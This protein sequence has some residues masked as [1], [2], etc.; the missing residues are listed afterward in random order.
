MA[1]GRA[2]PNRINKRERQER[3]SCTHSIT[4]GHFYR[5]AGGA[6]VLPVGS[7]LCP[8]FS[9]A[10]GGL[11]PVPPRTRRQAPCRPCS[12]PHLPPPLTPE[13]AALTLTKGKELKGCLNRCPFL[14]SLSYVPRPPLLPQACSSCACVCVPKFHPVRR[15][16]IKGC[17]TPT[18]KHLLVE[19][20]YAFGVILQQLSREV[21][22]AASVFWGG[23]GDDSDMFTL[24]TADG[25]GREEPSSQ[26]I[27]YPL[28]RTWAPAP[29]KLD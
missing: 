2:T 20:K 12:L 7:E 21:P 19:G 22:E 11:T 1:A 25:G 13:P 16:I 5:R 3:S 24:V 8:Q 17:L 29:K 9:P 15:Q 27:H 23:R 18:P 4:A 6:R 26:K 14:V 10:L 28:P